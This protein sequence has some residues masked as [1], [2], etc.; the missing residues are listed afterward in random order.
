[1]DLK[2]LA[3]NKAVATAAAVLIGVSALSGM[4]GDKA[5]PT[6]ETAAITET[7]TYE[8]LRETM[9]TLSA[10]TEVQEPETETEPETLPPETQKPETKSPETKPPETK[11]PETKAPETKPETKKPETKAPVIVATPE[12][13]APETKKAETKPPETKAPETEPPVTITHKDSTLSPE[14]VEALDGVAAFWAPTG[15]KI[16]LD[17]FCRSFYEVKYAGTVEEANTVK[18]GGWCGICSKDANE[19]TKSNRNATPE[20]IADCYSYQDY[21]NG[22]PAGAFD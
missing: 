6:A 16:H 15:K 8:D 18:E 5:E 14:L 20:V 19:N 3:N 21:I 1:M 2:K 12:T 17:P 13:K 11:K 22:I 4:G 9:V 10:E 7:Y